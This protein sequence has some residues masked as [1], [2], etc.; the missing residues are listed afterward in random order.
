MR[1]MYWEEK[2]CEDA[3]E[4]LCDIIM[5][6]MRAFD[7]EE[8]TEDICDEFGVEPANYKS[9]I[10]IEKQIELGDA[11]EMLCDAI[12]YAFD[13]L[14]YDAFDNMLIECLDIDN[15]DELAKMHNEYAIKYL[16]KY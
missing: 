6:L 12:L 14:N 11:K 5:W 3:R 7:S 9:P 15:A 10:D 16:Y 2:E 8:R 1:E 4:R 13:N